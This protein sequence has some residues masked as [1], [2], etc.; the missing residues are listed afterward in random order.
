MIVEDLYLSISYLSIS[1]WHHDTGHP[2]WQVPTL[3]SDLW[4]RHRARRRG[5]GFGWH[6]GAIW[7][8]QNLAGFLM[9]PD[10]CRMPQVKKTAKYCKNKDGVPSC[11]I[12]C[13]F[14][15]SFWS[16]MISCIYAMKLAVSQSADPDHS[17][18]KWCPQF[19]S[20]TIQ[21]QPAKMIENALFPPTNRPSHEAGHF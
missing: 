13:I 8:W 6:S 21:L 11:A 2:L 12:F 14:L 3:S 7:R 18:N 4:S 5:I 16:H 17:V 10:Q 19:T 1:V 9:V 20:P 15:R